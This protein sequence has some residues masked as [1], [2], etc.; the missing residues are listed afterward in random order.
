MH[1]GGF[2]KLLNL[3]NLYFNIELFKSLHDGYLSKT[4]VIL[5]A[6]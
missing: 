3:P 2:V 1:T 4:G 6:R 5:P